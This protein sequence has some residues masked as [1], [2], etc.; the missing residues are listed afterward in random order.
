MKKFI[1]FIFVIFISSNVY[2]AD[3]NF[4][5]NNGF[6]NSD[7]CVNTMFYNMPVEICRPISPWGKAV[8]KNSSIKSVYPQFKALMVDAHPLYAVLLKFCKSS[9]L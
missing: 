6:E 3:I 8:V 2:G 7:M 1:L 5:N 9:C 4:S